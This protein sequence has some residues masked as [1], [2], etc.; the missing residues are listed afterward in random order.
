MRKLHFIDVI[1]PLGTA[2]Q[3]QNLQCSRSG[4]IRRLTSRLAIAVAGR[5]KNGGEQD[6]PVPDKEIIIAGYHRR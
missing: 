2:Q 5:W 6:K 4:R 1:T 3:S